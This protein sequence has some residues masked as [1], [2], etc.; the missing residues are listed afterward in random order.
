MS[1]RPALS[2]RSLTP[3]DVA[4]LVR[5]RRT[6]EVAR[7][8]GEPERDFPFGD[9]P[10]AVRW[11]IEIDGLVVGMVQYSEETEPRYR[12]AAIDI[13]V[14]PAWHN[15][16]IGTEALRRT[17]RHLIDLCGHHRVT[18]DPAVANAA[19]I[20]A[21]EKVGFRAVGVMHHYERDADTDA[22]HDGLLM[23]LVIDPA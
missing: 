10:A 11:V 17:V 6:P 5:I 18:I 23:E 13:F 19:A 9:D 20:R 12:H 4:E 7:W 21:Y 22:W 8:W 2:L 14:D 1:E 3:D 15:R 16:D